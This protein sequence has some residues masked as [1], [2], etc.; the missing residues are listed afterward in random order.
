MKK[1]KKISADEL[2]DLLA[3]T[4]AIPSKEECLKRQKKILLTCEEVDDVLAKD[5][6]AVFDTMSTYY[7]FLSCDNC[8]TKYL[9]KK[10][11]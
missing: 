6:Q 10:E 2:W 11:E 7:H 5:D 4:G 9:K 1:R 3:Q 8:R